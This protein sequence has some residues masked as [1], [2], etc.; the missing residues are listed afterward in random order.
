MQSSGLSNRDYCLSQDI[1]HCRRHCQNDD[2]RHRN[3]AGVCMSG[4]AVNSSTAWEICMETLTFLSLDIFLQ[5][6]L[7][8]QTMSDT[9]VTH[10]QLCNSLRWLPFLSIP[11][12][13]RPLGRWEPPDGLWNQG[14]IGWGLK[15]LKALK[16]WD[17][18]E[19]LRSFHS[20][21]QHG[22]SPNC[23]VRWRLRRQPTSWLNHLKASF[24]EADVPGVARLA[25]L[26]ST[27]CD[28]FETLPRCDSQDMPA[29][30]GSWVYRELWQDSRQCN[31]RKC[32]A[33]IS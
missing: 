27:E 20:W 26:R 5:K 15:P 18:L 7:Y 28:T 1:R 31:A 32:H 33:D 17:L 12:V 22:Q 23:Q 9:V 6:H 25:L 16:P 4:A 29:G 24:L 10:S 21:W 11:H 8:S 3:T 2:N 30:V 13:L 19:P 14:D